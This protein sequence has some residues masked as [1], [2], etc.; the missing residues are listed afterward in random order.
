MMAILAALAEIGASL[1]WLD[2]PGD[3]FPSSG[4]D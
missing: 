4:V 1:G 2:W 3:F